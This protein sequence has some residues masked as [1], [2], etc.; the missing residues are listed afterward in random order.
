MEAVRAGAEPAVLI[1]PSGTLRLE[2]L[3]WAYASR[4]QSWDDWLLGRA[5][6]NGSLGQLSFEGTLLLA[7][8]LRRWAEGLA[9]FLTDPGAHAW[10]TDLVE[11]YVAMAVRSAADPERFRMRLD[12]RGEPVLSGEHLDVESEIEA[13][14]LRKFAVA[15]RRISEAFPPRE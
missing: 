12:I 2:V 11:P 14:A 8:E 13:P 4:Q 7:G 1:G 6:W 9:H 10:E 15:L 3:G 5:E